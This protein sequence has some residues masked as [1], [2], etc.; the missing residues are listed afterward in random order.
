M[1][2]R[3]SGDV[4]LALALAAKNDMCELFMEIHIFRF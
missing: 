1:K 2:G 4:D 3:R